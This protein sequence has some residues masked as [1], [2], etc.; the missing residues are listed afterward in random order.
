MENMRNFASKFGIN[1]GGD[2][3]FGIPSSPAPCMIKYN[4][5]NEILCIQDRNGRF[6]TKKYY[7]D[8]EKQKLIPTQLS[9]VFCQN[10]QNMPICMMEFSGVTKRTNYAKVSF[11]AGMGMP[12]VLE[13]ALC[14]L[15]LG[16]PGLERVFIVDQ[17]RAL[18]I[19]TNEHDPTIEKMNYSTTATSTNFQYLL[20]A[21]TKISGRGISDIET[22]DSVV[23][24]YKVNGWY[25]MK[26]TRYYLGKCGLLSLFYGSDLLAFAIGDSVYYKD[27]SSSNYYKLDGENLYALFSTII[28]ARHTII[29]N[30][31]KVYNKPL[32]VHP[33]GDLT[34]D[35][36]ILER[37]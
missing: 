7:D 22:S 27:E 6:V 30:K 13:V 4:K 2:T 1:N 14:D 33:K 10:S 35:I 26:Y 29:S 12:A 8:G 5:G 37:R 3:F 24:L 9:R 16:M 20:G 23:F 25:K 21:I 34:I 17:N 11:V 15:S 36:S 19:P 18:G 28:C 31:Q 32:P